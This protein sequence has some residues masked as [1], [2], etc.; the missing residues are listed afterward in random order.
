[1]RGLFPLPEIKAMLAERFDSIDYAGK[2]GCGAVHSR[3]LRAEYLERR[4]FKQ[5]TEGT[6]CGIVPD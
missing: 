4:L 1:M 2:A 6:D 5:I 3:F